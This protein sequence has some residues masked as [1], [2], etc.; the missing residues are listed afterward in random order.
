[1]LRRICRLNC[2]L[3]VLSPPKQDRDAVAIL[4]TIYE[5][6]MTKAIRF[7]FSDYA[8]PYLLRFPILRQAPAEGAIHQFDSAK[9][10]TAIAAACA[11][12]V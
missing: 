8:V 3:M 7:L 2:F 6:R 12:K 9:H 5:K 1:M 10:V 4:P 11:V